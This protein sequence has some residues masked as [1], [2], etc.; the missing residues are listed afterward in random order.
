MS[1]EMGGFEVVFNRLPELS[2]AM[3][4][5]VD[6]MVREAAIDIQARA[7][8][9]LKYGHGVRSGFLKSSI[10]TVTHDKST[11]GQNLEGEGELLPEVEKPA[12]SEH[13]A[14]IAVGA[15]Y[16]V[17]VEYGTSKMAAIPYL[18]PAADAVR[19]VFVELMSRL[20]ERLKLGGLG[21]EE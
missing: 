16:G 12:E 11:Y 18:L 5:V 4:K 8:A 9:S 10:Y 1:D 7:Q 3:E 17:Y 13:T 19:P 6:K 14:Y 21:G 2:E 15:E 20:E